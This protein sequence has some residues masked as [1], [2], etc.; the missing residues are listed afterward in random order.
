MSHRRLP[1]LLGMLFRTVTTVKRKPAKDRHLIQLPPSHE[2]NDIKLDLTHLAKY[3]AMFPAL[4]GTLPLT[5]FY[6][7]AQRAQLA[8]MLDSKFPFAIPGLVH[9]SNRMAFAHQTETGTPFSVSISARLDPE[10]KDGTER[11]I[12]EMTF[13]QHSQVVVRNTS[14]YFART[15]KPS[16]SH[17]SVRSKTTTRQE[18]ALIDVHL[19]KTWNLKANVGRQYAHLSGDY[20]PI[21][22]HKYL[23]RGFGFKQPIIHGMYLQ[24]LTQGA[25]E[26]KIGREVT[27]MDIHFKK[28]VMIPNRV[29]LSVSE[30]SNHQFQL[31]SGNLCELHLEGGYGLSQTSSP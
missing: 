22:L 26:E 16:H 14:V 8:M 9:V 21:H 17:D 25:I 12:F 27:M 29:E 30:P 4:K 31:R 19:S 11:I 18:K 2:Y 28:P 20:N 6:L 15:K 1:P 23:S 13:M 24:A 3:K 10:A 5:Y 7:L